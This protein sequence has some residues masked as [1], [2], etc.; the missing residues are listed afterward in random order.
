MSVS[1][2]QMPTFDFSFRVGGVDVV[3]IGPKE[4][5]LAKV[6]HVLFESFIRQE[7]L[8]PKRMFVAVNDNFKVSSKEK[9]SY[10]VGVCVLTIEVSHTTSNLSLIRNDNLSSS[11]RRN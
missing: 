10:P 6:I 2:L 3:N 9:S 5:N 1:F 4:A 8:Y 11:P 7:V